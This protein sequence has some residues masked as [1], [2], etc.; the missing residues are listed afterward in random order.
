MRS[1]AMFRLH[2][3]G[4]DALLLSQLAGLTGYRIVSPECVVRVCARCRCQVVSTVPG[5]SGVFLQVHLTARCGSSLGLRECFRASYPSGT[6][7]EAGGSFV[8]EPGC[9][10]ASA[11]GGVGD[12][13]FDVG[14]V[15]C[16]SSGFRWCL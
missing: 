6:E 13:R 9:G 7:W 8:V 2:C 3:E 15:H 14:F 5:S 16:F 12:M 11:L 4:T 1:H 10:V